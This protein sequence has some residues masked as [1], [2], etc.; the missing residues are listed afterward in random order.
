MYS[1]SLLAVPKRYLC[2]GSLLPVIDVCFILFSSSIYVRLTT[3]PVPPNSPIPTN[4]PI[5]TTGP[6]VSSLPTNGPIFPTSRPTF[7]R[8]FHKWANAMPKRYVFPRQ[9]DEE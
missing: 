3:G 2:C 4:G 5:L 8:H 1:P 9:C 6:I 7:E